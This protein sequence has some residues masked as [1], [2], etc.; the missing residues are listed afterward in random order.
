MNARSAQHS[1]PVKIQ[2][3]DS[4]LKAGIFDITFSSPSSSSSTDSFKTPS[5][6]PIKTFLLSKTPYGKDSAERTKLIESVLNCIVKLNLPL[7]IVDEKP[8]IQMIS[9]CNNRLRLPCRQTVSNKLIP[10]KA[11][12][13][14]ENLKSLLTSIR[15]CSLTCDGWTSVGCD[16][17]LGN[18]NFIFFKLKKSD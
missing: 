15:F 6:M 10:A 11:T 9:D 17:Y 13:A 14:K 7:S 2:L 16:S 18:F 4:P 8:F 5:P 1:T 3:T 12:L